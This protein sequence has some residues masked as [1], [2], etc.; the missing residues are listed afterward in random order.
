MERRFLG[1]RIASTNT[2]S[3][4]QRNELLIAR[5]YYMSELKRL[6]FDDVV[7]RLSSTFFISDIYVVRLLSAL[8]EQ[9][10]LM[11]AE[12]PTRESLRA[13]WPEWDWN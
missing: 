12:R 8:S 6:R 4:E 9:F 3:R 7:F 1:Y 2:I 13:K 11:K 10:D 5:Y